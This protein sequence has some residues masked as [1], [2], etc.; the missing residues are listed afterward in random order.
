M[1]FRQWVTSIVV[2]AVL[3]AG[4]TSALAAK[5]TITFSAQASSP[6]R[7]PV[8]EKWAERYHE[9][10]PNVTVDVIRVAGNYTEFL[11]TMMAAGTP[12]DVMWLGAAFYTFADNLL[13]LDDLFEKDPA[14]RDIHPGALISSRWEGRLLT[15]PHGINCHTMYYNK[16]LLREAGLE[17]PRDSWTWDE[18]LAMSKALTRDTSG[19]GQPDQWGLQMYWPHMAWGYGGTLY[20]DEGR[21]LNLL[22]PVRRAGVRLFADLRS[23]RSGVHAPSGDSLRNALAGSV[24]MVGR[25][26]FDVPKFREGAHFDWDVVGLPTLAVGTE[27]SRTTFMSPETWAIPATS[28]N[29]HEAKDYVRFIM[30]PKQSLELH[31]L[32]GVI[33]TQTKIAAQTFL[34]ISPPKNIIAFVEAMDYGGANQYWAHPAGLPFLTHPVAQQIWQG[35]TAVEVALS[36]LQRLFTAMMDEHFSR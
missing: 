21:S 4:N 31:A 8:Y 9:L 33:P 11:L 34:R 27:R 25:G 18:V 20:T 30:Q 28:P 2:A 1:R 36:E 32:G 3:T 35:A 6:E 16:D 15:I 13:P 24:A 19:D 26:V 17:F 12:I 14:I 23:G 22:D 5:T 29:I 10:N 7:F